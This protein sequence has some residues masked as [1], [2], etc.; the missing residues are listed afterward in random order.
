MLYSNFQIYFPGV[1]KLDQIWFW[2]FCAV[3]EILNI[4]CNCIYR[5]KISLKYHGHKT[6]CCSC[7]GPLPHPVLCDL[8]IIP[9]PLRI[10]HEYSKWHDISSACHVSKLVSMFYDVILLPVLSSKH[11][12]NIIERK[13]WR[14]LHYGP[15]IT[16]K[17]IERRDRKSQQTR[18]SK[19]GNTKR[20]YSSNA[21]PSSQN[22]TSYEKHTFLYSNYL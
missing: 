10:V 6:W 5:N 14:H 15:G 2:V 8:F 11:F 3:L 1:H 7:K 13:Y 22:L 4:I 9:Q 20:L 19:Q 21:C 16:E 17:F 18:I 12:N